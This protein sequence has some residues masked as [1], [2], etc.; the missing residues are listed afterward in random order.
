MDPPATKQLGT[1]CWGLVGPRSRPAPFCGGW[2]TGPAPPILVAPGWLPP[3]TA[4]SPSGS[5]EYTSWM[6]LTLEYVQ[7]LPKTDLHC[8]LDGS[9]RLGT[10]LELAAEHEVKLPTDVPDRL[11]QM[12]YPGDECRSL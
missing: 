12:I 3:P 5:F 4:S 8:H 11:F 1:S 9:L 6:A 2:S 10:I 7:K